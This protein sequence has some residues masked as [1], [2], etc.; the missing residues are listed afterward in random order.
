MPKINWMYLCDYA[1]KDVAGKTSIIGMFTDINALQLP[2]KYQQLFTIM[3]LDKV[4]SETFKLEV[5]I[6]SPSEKE[7][8]KKIVQEVKQQGNAGKVVKMT[9]IYAFYGIDLTEAGEY[10]L[11][12]FLDGNC[13]HSIPFRVHLI[14]INKK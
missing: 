12:L 4:D 6:S 11:L 2:T 1:Y 13:I 10:H 9:M 3:E 7:I 14:K 8:T 5:V